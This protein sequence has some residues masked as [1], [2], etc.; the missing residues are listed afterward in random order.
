MLNADSF[1][2]FSQRRRRK[3]LPRRGEGAGGVEAEGPVGVVGPDGVGAEAES[4]A[5]R[6]L[7]LP[8]STKWRRRRMRW[9]SVQM[10]LE[11]NKG[12]ILDVIRTRYFSFLSLPSFLCQFVLMKRDGQM[13]IYG[14]KTH[15]Y[16]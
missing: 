3:L 12:Q 6:L 13:W 2:A 14:K 9:L 4:V 7:P 15:A 10:G 16:F 8:S 1:F 11:G 5:A